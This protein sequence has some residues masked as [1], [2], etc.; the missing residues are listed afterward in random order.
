VPPARPLAGDV[1]FDTLTRAIAEQ[2]RAL[3]DAKR[4]ALF[5]RL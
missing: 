1:V 3:D 2:T 5:A 4:A